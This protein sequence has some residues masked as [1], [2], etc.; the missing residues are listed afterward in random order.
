MTIGKEDFS[1]AIN[2]CVLRWPPLTKQVDVYYSHLKFIREDAFKEMCHRFVE[3]FR[4]MPLVR[5]FKE[6]YSEW[7]TKNYT[8]EPRTKSMDNFVIQPGAN[9]QSCDKKHTVCI[10]EPIGSD[11][12]CRECYTGLTTKEI[13]GRLRDLGKMMDKRRYPDFWPVWAKDLEKLKDVPF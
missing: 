4:S 12:E 6:A 13:I 1:E 10:Q 3:D 2:E 9:C 11:W 7:R 5:D 8:K